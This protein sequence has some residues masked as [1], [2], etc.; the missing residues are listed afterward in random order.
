MSSSGGGVSPKRVSRRDSFRGG[1]KID[2][3]RGLVTV[4]P[5]DCFGKWFRKRKNFERHLNSL[6]VQSR[7]GSLEERCSQLDR[8]R[9]DSKN[10]LVGKT[11][12]LV[13][14]LIRINN[15]MIKI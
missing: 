9:I 7:C 13:A 5:R 3:V 15:V 10:R 14:N 8:V 1:A 11:T 4:I 6:S 2:D 12:N